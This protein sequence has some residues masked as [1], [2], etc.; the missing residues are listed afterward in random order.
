M[1]LA[2]AQDGSVILQPHNAFGGTHRVQQFVQSPQIH[3]RTVS[4]VSSVIIPSVSTTPVSVTSS[5]SSIAR[6]HANLIARLNSPPPVSVPDVS[7]LGVTSIGGAL[8]SSITTITVTTV[9]NTVPLTVQSVNVNSLPIASTGYVMQR[10]NL[11]VGS[12][13]T[14]FAEDIG[15]LQT[16][17][18]I[19]TEISNSNQSV[20][21][22]N[23]LNPA[24]QTIVV[25]SESL[26]NAMQNSLKT[27]Q[28]TPSVNVSTSNSINLVQAE[29]KTEPNVAEVTE[30][31]GAAVP[32]HN[33]PSYQNVPNQVRNI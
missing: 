20:Q 4:T 24:F 26:R 31:K 10:T 21:R 28:S 30:N 25:S 5:E 2:F 18:N 19:I 13:R 33:L 11:A 3:G 12:E 27:V 8:S 15:N 14:F 6:N 9:A 17:G 16:H 7:S 22:I 29:I 1:K 32:S 23:H